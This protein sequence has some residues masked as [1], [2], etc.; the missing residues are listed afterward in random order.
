MFLNQAISAAQQLERTLYGSLLLPL[1][2]PKGPHLSAISSPGAGSG[3]LRKAGSVRGT[4]G[5]FHLQEQGKEDGAR[6]AT[7]A[8]FRQGENTA[9]LTTQEGRSTALS[10]E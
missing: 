7:P 1:L 4:R 9:M 6:A 10:L 3:A 2:S 8:Q 5:Q